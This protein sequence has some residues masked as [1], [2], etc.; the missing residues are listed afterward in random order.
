MIAYKIVNSNQKRKEGGVLYVL[1]IEKAYNI[2][3]EVVHL[4]SHLLC[5]DKQQTLWFLS[6]LKG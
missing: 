6:Q 2:M 1:D 4:Y 5:A 3:D